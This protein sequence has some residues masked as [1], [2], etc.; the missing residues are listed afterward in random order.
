MIN[1]WYRWTWM[2]LL[3]LLLSCSV[4]PVTGEKELKL[5][6]EEQELAIGVKN[7]GPYRQAQGGDYVADPALVEYVQRVGRR[8]A[9]VADRGLPYEFHVINDS[10][11][12]AWALP[13]GKIA[14]NRGLLVELENEAQLAA[15]LAHEVVHAAA[16]HSVQSMQRGIFLQGALLATGVALSDAR[17]R[18]LGLVGGA[19]AAN[20]VRSHY[21]QEAEMEADSYGMRYMV[22]AG[23]DPAA[24]VSLQQMFVRL[25][26]DKRRDWLSGLFASHPPSEERVANNRRVLAALG[27]PGGEL[28]RER[29]QKA[30][31]RLRRARPAYEAHAKAL[32]AIG[33]GELKTASRLIEKA[34]R[35]EPGEALFR[36]AR[37]DI[38][39]REGKNRAAARDYER[40]VALN[41]DYFLP[42]LKRGLF[43]GERDEPGEARRELEKSVALL[44]TADA[45]YGL[46]LLEE[47]AGHRRQ[48]LDAFRKAGQSQSEAGRK[49]LRRLAILD[50]PG[51]PDR[52]IQTRLLRRK[53]GHLLLRLKNTSLLPV[54]GIRVVIGRRKG[55]VEHE[56]AALRLR[57]VL[58][59]GEALT[60]EALGGIYKPA[61]VRRLTARVVAAVP[62]GGASETDGRGRA[63]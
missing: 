18:Q 27:R 34:I 35:I 51:H 23:Y 9:A 48:A 3:P 25:F 56:L 36:L 21:S 7:Y 1:R 15:V 4:N 61:Q 17:Y 16:G 62:V 54:S 2:L 37:A 8:I 24:A 52:Y 49:A 13:G 44:P 41:P 31:A 42:H 46:G 39:K 20:L 47:K 5:I 6:G 29:F 40:A 55:R 59:A 10:T 28:G 63:R 12:N 50:L 43:L 33:K 26:R 11:P 60:V 30:I 57:G 32:K 53:D 19:L 14:I 45:Y 58:G 22:R 38:E